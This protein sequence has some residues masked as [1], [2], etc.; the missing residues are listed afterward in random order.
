MSSLGISARVN[1]KSI[2]TAHTHITQ[3]ACPGCWEGLHFGRDTYLHLGDYS[4]EATNLTNLSFIQ[5]VRK[6][7]FV[8]QIYY[9][10]HGKRCRISEKAYQ[11]VTAEKDIKSW[12][13]TSLH[14]HESEHTHPCI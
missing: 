10:F 11:L 9:A 1:E 6:L 12:V 3:K 14:T 7:H 13:L 5:E 8:E 2:I 4:K